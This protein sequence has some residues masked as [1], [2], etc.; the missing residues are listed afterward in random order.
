MSRWSSTRFNSVKSNRRMKNGKKLSD[1]R[2]LG[3]RLRSKGN[4]GKPRRKRPGM[5]LSGSRGPTLRQLLP[6]RGT[7]S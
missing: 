5:T 1:K 6:R 3:A 4:A 7:M 2:L